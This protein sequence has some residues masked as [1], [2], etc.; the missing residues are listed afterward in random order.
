MLKNGKITQDPKKLV[1]SENE[2]LNIHR[3]LGRHDALDLVTRTCEAVDVGCMKQI[4][5]DKLYLDV[6]RTWDEFCV[7]E[8]N[9]S[10]RKVD[11]MIHQLEELGPAYFE[12]GRIAR[13]TA[14]EFRLLGPAVTA[15]GIAMNGEVVAFKPENR[16]TLEAAVA[17]V[18]KGRKPSKRTFEDVLA[19]CAAL[20]AQLEKPPSEPDAA[21]KL[22]LAAA[23]QRLKEAAE[24]LGIVTVEVRR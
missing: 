7:K 11:T 18:R 2:K 10:R 5:D 3:W 13:V 9:A 12:L 1:A 8:L 17:S 23:M 19:A 20:A 14:E 16:E 6:A 15:E 21:Q 24:S 4:R 22:H